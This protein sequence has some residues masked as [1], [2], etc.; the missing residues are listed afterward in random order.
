MPHPIIGLPVPTT[1]ASLT[2]KL[3]KKKQKSKR[4]NKNLDGLYELLAPGLAVFKYN[5]YT[6]IIK[7]PAK[8]EF[9]IR[10]SD[11]EKFGPRPRNKPTS[12]ATWSDDQNFHRGRRRR[13]S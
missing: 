9:T 3:A 11:F 10:N 6:S 1:E 7:E 2:L 4:S 13:N 5:D 8:K 12:N